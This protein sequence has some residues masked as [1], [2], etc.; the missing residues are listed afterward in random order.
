MNYIFASMFV[1]SF[2]VGLYSLLEATKKMAQSG[3]SG[4][5]QGD[6]K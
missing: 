3:V 1:M 5:S 6:V 4:D 2:S